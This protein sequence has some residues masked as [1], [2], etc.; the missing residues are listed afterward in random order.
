MKL[1][2]HK[3]KALQGLIKDTEVTLA[4]PTFASQVLIQGQIWKRGSKIDDAYLSRFVKVTL[5]SVSYSVDEVKP[6]IDHVEVDQIIGVSTTTA[7]GSDK[8]NMPKGAEVGE[9]Q[10]STKLNDP[11]ND[12]SRNI[13]FWRYEDD[14]QEEKCAAF[15]YPLIKNGF[16]IFTAPAGV[17]RGRV[18]VFKTDTESQREKWVETVCRVVSARMD[19][20]VDPATALHIARKRVHWYY[21]GDRCQII[22]AA[23]IAVRSTSPPSSLTPTGPFYCC[24][25]P[26]CACVFY[27]LIFLLFMEFAFNAVQL[28]V[29][30]CASAK[31]SK[32]R[33]S[34]CGVRCH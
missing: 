28:F 6:V 31:R 10:D 21:M 2:I 9:G 7:L 16:A 11:E 33:R 12:G 19:K 17:Y 3:N 5:T 1:D 25:H 15:N 20:P 24:P 26:L 4:N 30:Y 14:L 34:K 13:V 8:S 23:L 32:R 18:F 29:K 27:F 22:V